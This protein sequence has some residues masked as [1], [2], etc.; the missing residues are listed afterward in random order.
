[1]NALPNALSLLRLLCAPGVFLLA[2]R[3]E[4]RYSA[5]VFVLLALT[6]ALDG[7]LA[8]LLK[9][10]TKTGKFLDPLADKV[11]LF[12]GLLTVTVVTE[13][14]DPLLIQLLLVRDAVL[15][16]GTLLLK[17]YGFVPEPSLWGKLTTLTVSVTVG[18]GFL[19][20]LYPEGVLLEAFR[21]LQIG[22]GALILIS[23]LDYTVKGVSFLLDKLII[24]RR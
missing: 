7:F 13:Q 16:G 8:R 11:L 22:S 3:G 5:L 18:A 14:A 10:E 23:A 20:S 6:D 17:R 12:F 9:A 19:V 24:E 21:Y 4:E 1:M 2:Y 15:I